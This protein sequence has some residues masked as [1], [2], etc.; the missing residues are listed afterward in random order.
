MSF[1]VMDYGRAFAIYPLPAL[2]HYSDHAKGNI[3]RKKER[4]KLLKNLGFA[5]GKKALA[6][7]PIFALLRDWDYA[8]D[9]REIK[10]ERKKDRRKEIKISLGLCRITHYPCCYMV[11]NMQRTI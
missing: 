8:K 9:N 3:E 2:L 5:E 11:V 1:G 6:L 7:H 4:K 10:N